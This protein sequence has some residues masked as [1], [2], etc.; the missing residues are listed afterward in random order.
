MIARFTAQDGTVDLKSLVRCFGHGV[1]NL[2]DLL[3]SLDNSLTLLVESELQPFFKDPADDNRMKT[4]EMRLHPLPWP[5]EQ[6]A[7]LGN[8]DVTM[9][10]TLSYF[11][12]PSPGER[13]WT[14]RYGYQSHGLR[15]AVR[16]A[17]ESVPAFQQRINKFGREDYEPAGLAD[18]GWRFGYANRSLTSIGS[19]HSD[20]W[21][22][23]AVELAARGHIAV[24]PTMGWW[25]KRPHLE[26]WRKSARYSLI[27]SIATPG[28]E[29]NIYTA[30]A[31]QIGVPIVTEI[32]A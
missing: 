32:P 21:V 15:F 14:P 6:L 20:I 16:N 25:N 12:E 22:G 2:R 26:G 19:L 13:G 1:P 4:R 27:V 7:A 24:Y 3:S 5:T 31:N 29:S 28:I 30:V 10:V 8:T 23:T 11:I 9:R 18:P 17:L